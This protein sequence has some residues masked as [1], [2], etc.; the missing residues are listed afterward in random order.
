MPW[1]PG[2]STSPRATRKRRARPPFHGRKP[3]SKPPQLV[4]PD[5]AKEKNKL[6]PS[7]YFKHNFWWTIE[8]EEPALAGA[9]Q[10]LGADR[11][12]FATDYPHEDPG[13]RMKFKDVELLASHDGIPE[14]D[15]ELIRSE[16][17]RRLFRLD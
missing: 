12:L 3:V 15:K 6:P 7:H 9:V 11:F 16:N 8:T 4:P 14:G 13:G 1:T 2:S 5:E 10:A 17:A